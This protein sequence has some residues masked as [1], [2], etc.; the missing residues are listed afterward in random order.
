MYDTSAIEGLIQRHAPG[1]MRQRLSNEA[2]SAL[3]PKRNIARV[4]WCVVTPE[5]AAIIAEMYA[6]GRGATEIASMLGINDSTARDWIRKEKRKLVVKKVS[7]ETKALIPSLI[8]GVKRT[9]TK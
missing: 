3:R 1:L 2:A 8:H 4:G 5:I 7:D 6:A 9:D